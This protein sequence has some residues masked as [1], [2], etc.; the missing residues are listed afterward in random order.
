MNAARLNDRTLEFHD[1]KLLVDPI[2]EAEQG[3]RTLSEL[4]GRQLGHAL[5]A[6]AVVAVPGW[7]VAPD[8][9]GELLLINEKP[10]FCCSAGAARP[11]S[12]WQ[13]MIWRCKNGWPA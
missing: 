9:A 7:D 8:Q 3:A 1:G 5:R 11:T 13:A 12:C 6:R 4:A 10:Q 2:L